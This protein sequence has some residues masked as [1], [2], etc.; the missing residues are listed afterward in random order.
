[1]SFDIRSI[2]TK[3]EVN[4]ITLSKIIKVVFF[5][6]EFCLK[7]LTTLNT[8][9]IIKIVNL[10]IFQNFAKMCLIDKYQKSE[11]SVFFNG[12]NMFGLKSKNLTAMWNP[13]KYSTNELTQETQLKF[14]IY[15]HQTQSIQGRLSSAVFQVCGLLD[16]SIV[17]FDL[18][19]FIC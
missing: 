1:M 13:P 9:S 3:F 11:K 17:Q 19:Q 16:H 12:T 7:A 10:E 2:C 8:L 4:T 5:C 14:C 15:V 18:F 6:K